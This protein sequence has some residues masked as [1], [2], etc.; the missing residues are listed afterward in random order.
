MG[1][2]ICTVQDFFPPKDLIYILT[3]NQIPLKSSDFFS[4]DNFP[5]KRLSL[6]FDFFFLFPFKSA[7]FF[8]PKDLYPIHT[9]VLNMFKSGLTKQG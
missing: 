4:E 3:Q 7:N 9:N 1:K 8:P 6:F 2:T 5:A